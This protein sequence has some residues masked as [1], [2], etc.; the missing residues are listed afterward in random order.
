MSLT[1]FTEGSTLIGSMGWERK[2]E[3]QGQKSEGGGGHGKV[4]SLLKGDDKKLIH[5]LLRLQHVPFP[6]YPLPTQKSTSANE[7]DWNVFP[8]CSKRYS[9]Q[10]S[11]FVAISEGKRLS[12]VWRTINE[13]WEQSKS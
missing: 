12:R 3:E 6:P 5:K 13:R 8:S 1:S 4:T 7:E 2:G 11:K 9:E 10:L